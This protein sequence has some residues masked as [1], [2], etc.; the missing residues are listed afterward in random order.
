MPQKLRNLEF[1]LLVVACIIN[2][3]AIVLVQLGALGYIDTQLVLLVNNPGEVDVARAALQK[4]D[5]DYA[6]AAQK[7]FG[8]TDAGFWV[9]IGDLTRPERPDQ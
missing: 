4:F 9:V 3:G 8:P 7:Q 1:G 6:P 5:L 2:S